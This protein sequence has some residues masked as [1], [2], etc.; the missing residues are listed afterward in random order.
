MYIQKYAPMSQ[1][2]LKIVNA[3]QLALLWLN[4]KCTN[5]DLYLFVFLRKIPL[6]RDDCLLK[7]FMFSI[8][9]FYLL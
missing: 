3:M 1:E 6:E 8:E 7:E 9:S 2:K 4:I 5:Q